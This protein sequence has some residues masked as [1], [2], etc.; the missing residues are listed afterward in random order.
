MRWMIGAAGVG[1]ILLLSS[2]LG[3][4]ASIT[5]NDNGSGRAAFHYRVSKMFARLPS[6]HGGTDRPHLA[7]PAARG[8]LERTIARAKGVSLSGV[9]QTETDADVELKG[10]IR[11]DS[12]AALNS[13][14]LF[15]EM[16]IALTR[17]GD[18]T[19]FTLLV[20]DQRAPL[21]QTAV[22][23]YR[24]LFAGYDLVFKITAPREI[25]SPLLLHAT[26][27]TD[28]KT[29]T[30]AISLFDYMQLSEKTEVRVGW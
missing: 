19:V 2:C 8:D 4:E 29:L 18:R 27:S 1:L 28:K 9:E 12:V 3:V 13:S 14:G 24:A 30:Y 16:P 20:S 21:D 22:E 7:L 23:A 5:L 15:D 11:F 25:V 10:D 6:N 26:L 17:E